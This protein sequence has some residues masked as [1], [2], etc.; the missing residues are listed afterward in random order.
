MRVSDIWADS[1]ITHSVLTGQM[2]ESTDF[3]VFKSG[4]WQE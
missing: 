1:L 4:A 2:K 3:G